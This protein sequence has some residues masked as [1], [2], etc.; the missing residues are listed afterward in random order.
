VNP[1]DTLENGA[2]AVE[3]W[4]GAVYGVVMAYCG[5]DRV[6]PWAT[7]EFRVDAPGCTYTGHYWSTVRGAAEDFE[8]RVHGLRVLERA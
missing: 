1:M 4:E 7:W 6:Q 8:D 3:V 2:T 5:P